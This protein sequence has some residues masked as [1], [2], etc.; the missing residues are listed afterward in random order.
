MGI[1]AAAA[2][3]ARPRRRNLKAGAEE[4]L[5]HARSYTAEHGHLAGVGAT[6]LH[7]GFP[8]GRWLAGQRS[9]QQRKVLSP[10]RQQAL[11]AIDPW[12]CPPWNLHWQ[13][14]YHRARDSAGSRFPQAENG[15]VD[16]DDSGAADWLWRQCAT[17]DELHPEQRQL[18]T[19]IG[20][21]T[22]VARTAR[23][24][25]RTAPK[26]PTTAPGPG[27]QDK[28]SHATRAA[29]PTTTGRPRARRAAEPKL[30]ASPAA[31]SGT[32]PTS[33]QASKQP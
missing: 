7:R 25:A 26:A 8:L 13:R 15:F 10:G 18:L 4:G 21:T 17:Y 28:T 2:A 29:D 23:E 20:I 1:D 14:N 31:V 6:T 11:N 33:G 9:Q 24:R 19:Y 3:A 5:A 22:T 27:T 12:W 16:L 30:P 32:A